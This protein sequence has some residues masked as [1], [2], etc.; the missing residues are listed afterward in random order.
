[1]SKKKQGGERDRA[2]VFSV[3]VQQWDERRHKDHEDIVNVDEKQAVEIMQRKHDEMGDRASNRCDHPYVHEALTPDHVGVGRDNA[4]GQEPVDPNWQM[5]G[6]PR[7]LAQ[8][9]A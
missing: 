3:A 9:V 5:D 7:G 4:N 6:L 2:D 1:M 8:E